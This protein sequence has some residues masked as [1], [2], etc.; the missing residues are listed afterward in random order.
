MVKGEAKKLEEKGLAV[1][2]R[3][4]AIALDNSLVCEC[5]AVNGQSE[6]ELIK[7]A[8]MKCTLDML[9]NPAFAIDF[10]LRRK[11]NKEVPLTR[12]A[13]IWPDL[14]TTHHPCCKGTPQYH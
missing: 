2:S 3:A 7:D 13:W 10:S 14:N 1:V 4:F 12:D 9:E 11:L 8:K 6:S 5:Q